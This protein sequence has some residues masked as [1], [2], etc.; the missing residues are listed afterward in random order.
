M[1]VVLDTV[2]DELH[3]RVSGTH[4]GEL[5]MRHMRDRVEAVGGSVSVVD[6]DGGVTLDI[7]APATPSRRP[8]AAVVPT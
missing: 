3:L 6:H 4:D 7:R 1:R 2:G 5:P 8:V